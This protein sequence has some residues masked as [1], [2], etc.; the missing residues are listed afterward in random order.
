MSLNIVLV[1]PEIPQNTGNIA[2]TCTAIGACLHLVKPM[3]FTITDKHV[4]RAG[5]DYWDMLSLQYHDSLA[6]FMASVDP[7]H[8]IFASTKASTIYSD[9]SLSDPC[10]LVFGKETAGLPEELLEKYIHRSVR[11]PMKTEARS[12]NL[13]NAV[14]IM[15]YDIM[16]RIDFQGL[17][18]KGKLGL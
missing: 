15:A 14:A 5:L 11:I 3:A 17:K 18:I 7:E 12:L 10:Y 8:C 1:E 13:S 6:E 2:R 9:V 16:R 4:K